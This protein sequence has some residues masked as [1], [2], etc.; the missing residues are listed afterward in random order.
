[1]IRTEDSKNGV[2]SAVMYI[3]QHLPGTS[4]ERIKPW[5]EETA[6]V[7]NVARSPLIEYT[8]PLNF[9]LLVSICNL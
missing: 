8:D 3:L 6:V 9:D 2:R 4:E 1:M 5:P 7:E